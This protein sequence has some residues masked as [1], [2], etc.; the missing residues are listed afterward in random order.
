MCIL[1]HGLEEQGSHIEN[2]EQ[3]KNM[4]KPVE[5]VSSHPGGKDDN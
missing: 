3:K 4:E 5:E 2:R 1:E